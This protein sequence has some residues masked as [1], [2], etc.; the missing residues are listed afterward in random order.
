M[1]APEVRRS[2]V[3]QRRADTAKLVCSVI[4]CPE[5]GA[6][7]RTT[8]SKGITQ[9]AHMGHDGWTY[10]MTPGGRRVYLTAPKAQ[11]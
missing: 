11:P 1:T 4:G 8:H 9:I 10:T 7:C 3:A 5:G 6:L 2:T